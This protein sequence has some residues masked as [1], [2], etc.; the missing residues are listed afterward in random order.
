MQQAAFIMLNSRE[1][2][3][4]EAD[5]TL[6][7]ESRR[8]ALAALQ[9]VP[10]STP[11]EDYA[12]I[13]DCET[14]ALVSRA[15][16][17]DWLCWPRFDSG[18]CFPALLGTP[19]NGRWVIEASEPGARV[20]R[21]YRPNTLIL[22]TRVET[23]GGVVTVIDFMPPR[24]RNSDIVRLV[25]GDRGSVAM[26]TELILR[27]DY[28]RTIPW[29]SRLPDGTFRAI[30]GPDMVTLHTPVPL[31]GKDLTPSGEFEVAAGTTVPF[32]LTRGPSHLAPPEAIDPDTS[33]SRTE[34][35]WTEWAA[36]SQ[37]RGEWSEAVT[38]TD[39][40]E[41]VDLCAHRRPGR[42]AHD[43]AARAVWRIQKLGLSLL[44][45]AGCDVNVAGA[46][47]RRILRGGAVL[48]RLAA[49]SRGGRTGAAANHVWT[50][51]RA[52]LDR[53]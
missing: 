52:A 17:I 10:A 41:G 4:G 28:G 25:Q 34:T 53:I 37:S 38:I 50:G 48:A 27:F 14:A 9:R 47:E 2:A 43:L 29:V 3:F 30:A 39:H 13:G 36:R 45:A 5:R 33:L 1:A 15:G 16:S 12:L 32:V 8:A 40:A 51:R 19:D 22:E 23:S 46:D 20:S 49:S 11:L 6:V 31:R 18:A 42:S 35:F 24:G 44:L 21:R 7:V 26:R